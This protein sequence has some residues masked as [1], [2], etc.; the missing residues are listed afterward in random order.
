MEPVVPAIALSGEKKSLRLKVVAL[1]PPLKDAGDSKEVRGPIIP[2]IG[3][4]G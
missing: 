1:T 2:R 4:G 3:K